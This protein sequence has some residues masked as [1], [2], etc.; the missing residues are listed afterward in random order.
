MFPGNQADFIGSVG[1][2][3]YANLLVESCLKDRVQPV[4][5]VLTS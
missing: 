5:D 1:D 4:F 3:I 2:D